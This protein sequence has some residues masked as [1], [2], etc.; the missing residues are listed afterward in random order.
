MEVV[1]RAVFV[2]AAV[3]LCV[4]LGGCATGGGANEDVAPPA[5]GLTVTLSPESGVAPLEVTATMVAMNDDGSHWSPTACGVDWGV[6]NSTVNLVAYDPTH[7]FTYDSP[8]TRTVTVWAADDRR[9]VSLEARATVVVSPPDNVAPT[10]A[11]TA[12]A[13]TGLAPC[14]VRFT[15]TGTD[16]DGEIVSYQINFGDGSLNCSGTVA[17]SGRAHTYAEKGRYTATLTVTDDDGATATA[18][19]PITVS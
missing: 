17:P 6:Y 14:I 16:T 13:D 2:C 12:D 11:L 1:R 10:C 8:G 18:E 9:G 4:W 15:G 3:S 5:P 7:T 19:A